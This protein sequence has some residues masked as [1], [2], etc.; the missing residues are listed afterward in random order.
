MY[1]E[2]TFFVK[3][4][5]L[6]LNQGIHEAKSYQRFDQTEHKKKRLRFYVLLGVAILNHA[7]RIDDT[8]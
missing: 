4:Q 1:I 5:T 7:A 2:L 3:A 6:T 8:L